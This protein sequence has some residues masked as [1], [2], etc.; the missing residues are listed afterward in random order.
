MRRVFAALFALGTVGC[1]HEDPGFLWSVEVVGASDTC[2]DP[3]V[4]Y[5]GQKDFDYVLHYVGADVTIDLDGETMARGQISGCDIF[6]QTVVWG[7]ED[8]D[9]FEVRWQITGDALFR[10]GG[11]SCNL[12][13]G[14]DWL[15]T[16]VFTIVSSEDPGLEVGCTY[17]LNMQG[18]YQGA[19]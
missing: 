2:H 19:G 9:G 11:T 18:T 7:E 10:A 15:G 17:Q 1:Q 4:S 6:Y 13:E 16:E 5:N 14:V 12:D 8:D 3:P